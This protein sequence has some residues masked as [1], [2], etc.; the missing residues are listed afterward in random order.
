MAQTASGQ[1]IITHTHTTS[2]R[3][4][5]VTP[6]KKKP[7]APPQSSPP[8]PTPPPPAAGRPPPPL[9]QTLHP[10]VTCQNG[11]QCV[12]PPTPRDPP[13]PLAP[14]HRGSILRGQD[15]SPRPP[16]VRPSCP[17]PPV[18]IIGPVS[19]P[20]PSPVD[21]WHP[22]RYSHKVNNLTY[23]RELPLMLSVTLSFRWPH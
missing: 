5:L 19:S 16:E 6:M 4:V 20:T 13:P 9:R 23:K 18:A 15:C 3:H 21:S 17:P 8:P 12:R 7:S 14:R 1:N 2:P 22:P 10:H 11:T